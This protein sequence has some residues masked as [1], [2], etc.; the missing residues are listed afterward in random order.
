MA[1]ARREQILEA[2]ARLFACHGIA[3]ARMADVAREAGIA[4]GSVY[5][6]FRNK[7]E[8]VEALSAGRFEDVLGPMRAAAQ[9]EGAF[10]VRLAAVA[11]ARA[12]ALLDLA[13]D[14]AHGP[15]LLHRCCPGAERAWAGF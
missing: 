11:T 10:G 6:E 4:V 12:R 7:D 1:E 15:D 8:I 13:R 5:L 2:A 3:K 14:D 9:S